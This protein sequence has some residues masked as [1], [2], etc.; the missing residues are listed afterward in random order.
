[1]ENI[2]VTGASS[3]FGLITVKTLAMKGHKVFAAMRNLKTKNAVSA[4]SL[5]EWASANNKNVDV[6]ELDVTNDES[7]KNAI[8]FIAGKTNGIIDVLV[9][10]AGS[11]YI[12][13]NETLSASQTNHIFQ[14]NVIAVDR[15]IKAV[16]PYMHQQKNGLL[17]TLSSVAAR[18][19]TPVMGIY[20]ASKAA[21]DALSVS[22]SYELKSAGIDVAIIQPGAYQTTDIIANQM[23]PENA[24]A[25]VNYGADMIGYKNGVLKYFQPTD[26][27]RDPGEVARVIASLISMPKGERPLW[28]LAGAGVLT[29][30]INNINSISKQLVDD[31]VNARG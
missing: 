8:E 6:V 23:A 12:G 13:L 27:S 10:N 16:L 24:A 5:M 17:V 9:N 4:A 21:V 22:Y 31:L 18:Q 20:A 15:M 1:M 30:V 14:V 2:I 26:S 7:V 11:A 29:E 3:G 25:E 19:A 28:T